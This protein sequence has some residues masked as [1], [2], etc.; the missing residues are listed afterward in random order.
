M[1][2]RL[3][4]VAINQ[5][6]AR[7]F[8]RCVR[9][10]E[11]TFQHC[12]ETFERFPLKSF[13]PMP[14]DTTA[15][16]ATKDRLINGKWRSGRDSYS[17]FAALSNFS[18]FC[19]LKARKTRLFWPAGRVEQ[20]AKVHPGSPQTATQTGLLTGLL[21]GR[22]PSD[23]EWSMGRSLHKLSAKRVQT[24]RRQGKHSDGGGLNLY[25][26]KDGSKRWVFAWERN[27]KRHE[28]GLGSA[29][30][31]SLARARELAGEAREQI[32]AGL[33]PIEERR[34]A[35][36]AAI[37]ADEEA[38][39]E[40]E[41]LDLFGKFAESYIDTHEADWKNP[42]H[43]QQWCNTIKTYGKPILEKPL[44]DVTQKDILAILE[45]IWRVIPETAGRLRGRIENILDAAKV[46]GHIQSPWE[47]PARWKG[48]LEHLLPK[49]RSKKQ[50]RH[51]AAMPF[52]EL[53]AFW[54]SLARRP[55]TAARALELTILCATRTNETL[56]MTWGEV[57]L[58]AGIWTVPAERMKMG[59][60]H[61][62]PLPTTAVDIL[63]GR[64]RKSNCHADAFVFAGQKPGKPLSQ[65]AMTMVLR[66]M[67]L[68]HYTVHGMRS[69]FRDYMGEMTDHPESVVEQALAH[70]IGDETTR[71][72]RRRDAFLKRRQLMADWESYVIGRAKRATGSVKK[73]SKEK[74]KQAA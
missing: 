40:A 20:F 13:L 67:K 3:A 55:A 25:I 21:L 11:D 74:L 27:R 58:D 68:G 62:I 69:S 45:P 8:D 2:A 9:A 30:D 15:T 51:H 46:A 72:Y 61:R 33:N 56:R 29:L 48:N 7:R 73:L 49:R 4:R 37:R 28:M 42:K 52:E 39:R 19:Y 12:D 65:M 38:A 26:T 54:Q 34:L 71:A 35:I 5:P 47:N 70:Q 16:I 36:E 22:E 64:A 66:R 44:R 63:K 57:D 32:T 17:Q 23:L 31:V 18:D 41:N 50:A 59:I 53:P 43:R 6:A 14:N 24:E 60:A 10:C 1:F